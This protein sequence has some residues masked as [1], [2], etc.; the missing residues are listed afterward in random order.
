MKLFQ[1]ISRVINAGLMLE[2]VANE[3]VGVAFACS[4]FRT[5]STAWLDGGMVAAATSVRQLGGA[6]VVSS[7]A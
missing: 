4:C 6:H 1:A 7:R 2:F 3:V 5:F